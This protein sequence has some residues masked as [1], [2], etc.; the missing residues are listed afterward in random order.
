VVPQQL[1]HQWQLSLLLP[2]HIEIWTYGDA[3][4]SRSYRGTHGTSGSSQCGHLHVA[5]LYNN[6]EHAQ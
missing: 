6:L 1:L 2:R 5:G 4:G 3:G